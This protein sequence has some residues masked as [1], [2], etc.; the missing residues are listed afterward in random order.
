[1]RNVM[2]D[3]DRGEGVMEGVTVSEM[4]LAPAALMA[5]LGGLRVTVLTT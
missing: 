3:S 5:A 2:T 1:M 4:T